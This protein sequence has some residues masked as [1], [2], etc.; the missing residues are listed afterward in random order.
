MPKPMIEHPEIAFAEKYAIAERV[1]EEKTGER[2][3]E[4]FL[5]ALELMR[6]EEAFSHR[7]FPKKGDPKTLLIT[8]I[9]PELKKLPDPALYHKAL[10]TLFN[11]FAECRLKN[12]TSTPHE[13]FT[14][15][16]DD[17]YELALLLN[18]EKAA[19]NTVQAASEAC[20]AYVRTLISGPSAADYVA[21]N[22]AGFLKVL[23]E[24][25]ALLNLLNKALDKIQPPV[26]DAEHA[27]LK[28]RRFQSLFRQILAVLNCTKLTWTEVGN[29]LFALLQQHADFK[30]YVLAQ[31][32]VTAKYIKS[33]LARS[34]MS[35]TP[36]VNSKA[37]FKLA[38]QLNPE[39]RVDLNDPSDFR[40]ATHLAELALLSDKLTRFKTAFADG[41]DADAVKI[42]ER[43]YAQLRHV[44]WRCQFHKEYP[45][46]G[47]AV[48]PVLQK[49]P[50]FA[51]VCLNQPP[52]TDKG[53]VT[54]QLL[55]DYLVHYGDSLKIKE[56][57]AKDAYRMALKINPSGLRFLPRCRYLA[58]L[59]VANKSSPADQIEAA[60]LCVLGLQKGGDADQSEL[61]P[62]LAECIK[63]LLSAETSEAREA[64]FT[65]IPLVLDYLTKISAHLSMRDAIEEQHRSTYSSLLL[66]LGE[67]LQGRL[68]QKANS[69][70]MGA[71]LFDVSRLRL[72]L[73][74]ED[75]SSTSLMN[76]F[77]EMLSN[78]EHALQCAT[79]HPFNLS[80]FANSMGLK[81]QG[82]NIALLQAA[83][84]NLHGWGACQKNPARA[85]LLFSDI[86]M[87]TRKS[88]VRG[89]FT[90]TYE[91]FAVRLA[92]RAVN[93]LSAESVDPQILLQM[94]DNCINDYSTSRIIEAIAKKVDLVKDPCLRMNLY[95]R[96]CTFYDNK[97]RSHRY[98]SWDCRADQ[99]DIQKLIPLHK[100]LDEAFQALSAEQKT[101]LTLD[102]KVPKLGAPRAEYDLAEVAF[103]A[104]ETLDG[105]R[106]A[107]IAL[108]LLLENEEQHRLVNVHLFK[109]IIA[110][111][112]HE[113]WRMNRGYFQFREILRKRYANKNLARQDHPYAAVLQR[114]LSRFLDSAD[115]GQCL[116]SDL[117]SLYEA[118]LLWQ[119]PRDAFFHAKRGNYFL[120]EKRWD[121]AAQHYFPLIEDKNLSFSERLD[122][123]EIM[124][125]A[126]TDSNNSDL[127]A[128]VKV[129][130]D[131]FHAEFK[132]K[133]ADI[134]RKLLRDAAESAG[135]FLPILFEAGNLKQ[136]KELDVDNNRE[137]LANALNE[138]FAKG[139][140]KRSLQ[141]RLAFLRW[142]S[143]Q[144]QLRW[145][146]RDGLE[147]QRV[148]SRE[149]LKML[150]TKAG[151]PLWHLAAGSADYKKTLQKDGNDPAKIKQ[152][153][154]DILKSIDVSDD[155]ELQ[156]IKNAISV[157]DR[158]AATIR[159]PYV[160]RSMREIRYYANLDNLLALDFCARS[161]SKTNVEAV[162]LALRILVL[163]AD[164]ANAQERSQLPDEDVQKIRER[165]LACL[166]YWAEQKN[167]LAIW[168]QTQA[169]SGYDK[170]LAN[171]L[172]M[173][174]A[175]ILAAA[176]P[177]WLQQSGSRPTTPSSS[178]KAVIGKPTIAQMNIHVPLA[179]TR[180]VP[181]ALLGIFS[182][183]FAR[184][185]PSPPTT[186]T[187]QPVQTKIVK[188][189][190]ESRMLLS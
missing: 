102:S 187:A 24:S 78:L 168:G 51:D 65:A 61:Q 83:L 46:I 138:W 142:E 149:V 5:A 151:E 163:T 66:V 95:D 115:A 1:A 177:E 10:T 79:D 155:W 23:E 7:H 108:D 178:P 123:L 29:P 170:K 34:L 68:P 133:R 75:M 94:L 19:A 88:V 181:N 84:D 143:G 126:A 135:G 105:I 164:Q 113:T 71:I 158:I 182:R 112:K 172:P 26:G 55:A 33:K 98:R 64:A 38:Y 35:I 124:Q 122:N 43:L 54:V 147:R 162:R 132:P 106:H 21:D 100:G 44:L 185:M 62:L 39:F 41:L 171:K 140:Y 8:K 17:L 127:I 111:L 103:K 37:A 118:T 125:K 31:N 179:D 89:C 183:M 40:L 92:C 69:K 72:R 167:T 36:G 180:S 25:A 12:S 141:E 97:V 116:S 101:H 80:Y 42:Q 18:D 161:L 131:L 50:E 13:R 175:D 70:E 6:I 67:Q 52:N 146:V 148:F 74:E 32:D 15:A 176:C 184:G 49:H 60:K 14:D 139:Y 77:E 63:N 173:R 110:G 136:N 189:P 57:S 86:V 144:A 156:A 130:A 2:K 20:L 165:A 53:E 166:A 114:E 96:L 169:D 119:Q 82:I 120:K 107:G 3:Y 58:R 76:E 104:N 188:A 48:L 190:E 28:T 16:Q 81:K 109:D 121:L 150:L 159:Q 154:Q 117:C 134:R 4:C 91:A 45:E 137:L 152:A 160:L 22:L 186:P 11:F 129:K 47:K 90:D 93:G 9:L 73:W 87:N 145:K 99:A 174:T 157:R 85:A 30:D 59:L 27:A 128:Q 153:C 56:K